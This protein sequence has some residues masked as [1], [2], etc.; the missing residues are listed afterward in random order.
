MAEQETGTQDTGQQTESGGQT[1]AN[2]S[3]AGGITFTAEQ[4][5]HINSLIASERRNTEK[6]TRESDE[7]K[8]LRAKAKR[9]DELEE[10]TKSETEKLADRAAKAEA[11]VGDLEGKYRSALIKT[12]FTTAAI[13]A[14]IPAD[15]VDAALKLADMSGVDVGEDGTVSGMDKAIKSLPAWLSTVETTPA[16]GQRRPAPNIN[17][18]EQNRDGAGVSR[19]AAIEME[20]QRLARTGS[21]T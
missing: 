10:A 20:K 18:G 4:Q 19:E 16:N 2:T 5:A 14:N 8:Q 3:G 15:R 17:A 11:K 13:T 7:I 6:Q 21:Y 9:A 1:G 12:K